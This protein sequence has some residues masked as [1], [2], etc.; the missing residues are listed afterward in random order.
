[1]LSLGIDLGGTKIE[2]ALLDEAGGGEDGEEG[3]GSG[4]AADHGG[5]LSGLRVVGADS[6]HA[7]AAPEAHC[8]EGRE[9]GDEARQGA[10]NA[11][12]PALL[13]TGLA[14]QIGAV[15]RR[16]QAS[17]APSRRG[18]RRSATTAW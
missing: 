2:A 7:F 9:S 16:S 14:R 13:E 5:L 11:A 17:A 10:M 4:E 6:R 12:P 1:M 8:D 3:G 18:A 15:R